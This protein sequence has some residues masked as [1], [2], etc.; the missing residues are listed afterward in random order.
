M[1]C[2]IQFYIQL[3]H[4]LA[5][6]RP[7]LKVLA[8]KLVIFL[9]FWQSFMIS[10]L[11]SSTI[12]VVSPTAKI[13]YPDLKVG[14]P[15]LLL[16]V[17]MA[18]FSVLHLFA[19]P[20]KPYTQG[21]AH[22][23]YPQS[24]SSVGPKL[25]ELGPKQGGFL[26]I[27]AIG[28]AMNPW[29]LVKGFARGM[30]WLFVGRKNRETDPSYKVSS[31]DIN[32]PVNENDMSLGPTGLA[33]NGYKGTQEL[34][35][36]NEFRRSK[37]GMPNKAPADEEREGLVAHAQPNPL[38]PGGSG[39]VPAKQRYDANGQ[40]ISTGGSR[41]DSPYDQNPDR[42]VGRNPNPGTIR[43]QQEGE[44]IGMAVSGGPERYQSHVPQQTYQAYMPPQSSG[45][46]YLEQ[47]REARR[48]EAPSE[49]WANATQR[50]DQSQPEV[51]N[52]LWGSAAKREEGGEF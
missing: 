17:E 30:R 9:S 46:A 37:F 24:P 32:N 4:D 52:A 28:D 23:T 44:Q 47:K 26:G 8:I 22:G 19:F 38:N 45:D 16:C 29:D 36:A 27:K 49:Q 43:R 42:L 7:F 3:R 6:Y 20:Y 50:R 51:H 11:T 13:A 39:Y 35:I 10:I 14:I 5:P 15:S 12:K 25:N 21:V 31:F 2:V 41:Y 1:Y 48:L 18:M 40:D 34:P 33:D